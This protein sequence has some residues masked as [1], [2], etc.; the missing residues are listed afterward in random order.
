M[1]AGAAYR[2]EG[3][4]SREGQEAG[5]QQLVSVTFPIHASYLTIPGAGTRQSKNQLQGA[6]REGAEVQSGS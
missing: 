5:K 4:A 3:T 2:G 6:W 1:S